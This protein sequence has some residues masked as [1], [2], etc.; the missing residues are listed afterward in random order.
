MFGKISWLQISLRCWYSLL[1]C[2]YQLYIQYLRKSPFPIVY[3]WSK[4]LY[5]IGVLSWK[6]RW[7]WATPFISH[8]L[9]WRGLLFISIGETKLGSSWEFVISRVFHQTDKLE[10]IIGLWRLSVF[11]FYLPV[12]VLA[13][14][15]SHHLDLTI[16]KG[17]V[18]G[19][20]SNS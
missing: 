6:R 5:V 16:W 9:K 12:L 13:S 20:P 1:D 2:F 15:C 14:S 7:R 3:V 19:W 8:V 10:A 17:I 11:E 4:S 18:V